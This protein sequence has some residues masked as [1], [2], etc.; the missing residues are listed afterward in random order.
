M[1]SP[2]HDQSPK[3]PKSSGSN[4]VLLVD[5]N[6]TNLQVLS[7]TLTGQ[8][9]TL[10][11]ARSG[12]EAL[13]IAGEA[14]PVLILLDINMPGIGGFETCRRLKAD[15]ATSNAIVVF[16]SAR[17]SV[18]D[19]VR[20]L[21]L[22]AADYILKPFDVDEVL[23]RVRTH[24]Q[25]YLKHQELTDRNRELAARAGK[26]GGNLEPDQLQAM[27]R[28]GASDRIELKSTMRW[29][30]KADRA[31]KEI[32]NAWLKTVVAFLNTEGGILIIG[33]ADDG[34]ALGI[35][36]DRFANGDRY[37]LHV[38][39]L[40]RDSIGPGFA[41]FIEFSLKPITGKEALVVQCQSSPN[42]AFLR[43]D[44]KEEFYIR[45]GPGSRKL[46]PSEILAYVQGKATASTDSGMPPLEPVA[47][48]R[49]TPSNK[50]ILLVDDNTENLNVLCQT[51]DGR[52]HDLLVAR[53]G[54]EA[55]ETAERA[56]PALVLLD[57]MMPPGI[58]GY[59][60]CQRLH[61][62]H[63]TRNIPV[64]FMSALDETKD[65]VRG[66]ELGAVDYITKPFQAEEVI[67]RVDTHLKIQ[68]LQ[69]DLARRN[70]DLCRANERMKCDLDAAAELQRSLLP[71]ELPGNLGADF[72]WHF[73]PCDELGGDILNVLPLDEHN[74]AM[75]LLDVSGHGVSAA[76]LS[77][78]LSHV[79]T[80]RDTRSS[81]LVGDGDGEGDGAAAV[82][83][84]G[85]VAEHLNRRF[86]MESHGGRYF[87]MAYAILDTSTRTLRYTIAGHPPPVLIR[88][89][90]PP[91]PLE[92]GDM[93]IG[94]LD[95]TAYSTREFHLESGDRVF[96]YSDGIT[97]AVNPADDMLGIDG[98]MRWLDLFREQ[99]LEEDVH[100]C[101]QR[102]RHWCQ[103][104]PFGDDVSILAFEV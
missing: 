61:G 46:L 42:P 35:E 78:T 12:E 71:K 11:I 100:E 49:E 48:D 59:E 87:T 97:E 64:I 3:S 37:L 38:N 75:Y 28:A 102:L 93:A 62:N 7:Q 40:I 96:F 31:G 41:P 5:D 90:C 8:G 60:T 32:E 2:N 57:I 18:E 16:L 76:L 44:G 103:D 92:G 83:R 19:K 77:V 101:L 65:K 17:G 50:R 53:S 51:L 63:A 13:A 56:Q 39:N 30:L 24:L 22:G 98:L 68:Q 29:N 81:L 14:Q 4:R 9:L 26:S 74:I 80:A 79:L 55:L 58:D 47:T 6:P 20:G 73:E 91:Q 99:S 88:P 54:E 82:T 72:A 67:A 1:N 10:L 85:V 27:I 69:R 104:V 43:R 95:D 45:I 21:E 15:P 33:V 66:L 89:D 23:A 25:S 84:P 36:P 70:A 94:F 86:P 34:T 52:G